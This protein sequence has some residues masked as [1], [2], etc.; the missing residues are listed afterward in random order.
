[1]LLLLSS[2]QQT[3]RAAEQARQEL[4]QAQRHVRRAEAQVKATKQEKEA[5]WTV[6]SN[7]TEQAG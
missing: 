5:E 6:L 2:R 3:R 1:M 7:H 4:A